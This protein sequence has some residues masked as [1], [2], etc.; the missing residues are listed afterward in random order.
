MAVIH[1]PH[2]DRSPAGQICPH[3][4]D[5]KEADYAK[6]FTGKK[7]ECQL[8]CHLCCREPDK[9]EPFLVNVCKECFETID[10]HGA[11]EGMLGKPEVLARQRPYPGGSP[12]PA[13]GGALGEGG[14]TLD[15][16]KPWSQ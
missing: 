9:I 2:K 11:W 16:G 6:R 3:L 13:F 7:W 5:D 4:L 8:I 14:R 1:C 12:L 10:E 15:D